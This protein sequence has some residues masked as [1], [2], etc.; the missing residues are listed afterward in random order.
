MYVFHLAEKWT[1]SVSSEVSFSFID[2]R[3]IV[4][5][6]LIFRIAWYEV[7]GSLITLYG[8]VFNNSAIRWQLRD[9]ARF[10][11][12]TRHTSNRLPN[13]CDIFCNYRCL[14]RVVIPHTMLIKN[15]L[16]FNICT[17]HN[18]IRCTFIICL[19]PNLHELENMY[20]YIL[21]HNIHITRIEYA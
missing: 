3:F 19:F 5:F 17:Q 2:N 10:Y 14:K 20:I 13:S 16:W 9:F 15:R 11:V 18:N 7:W 6:H 8:F 12:R 1:L 4:N 21:K